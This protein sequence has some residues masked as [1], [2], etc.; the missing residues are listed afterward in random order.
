[1]TR[2]WIFHWLDGICAFDISKLPVEFQFRAIGFPVLIT[3]IASLQISALVTGRNDTCISQSGIALGACSIARDKT[4]SDF[5]GRDRKD[6]RN[7]AGSTPLSRSSRQHLVRHNE[8]VSADSVYFMPSS[9]AKASTRRHGRLRRIPQSSEP[10]SRG[11]Y[12]SARLVGRAH[13]E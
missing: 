13:L 10:T 11:G 9:L 5:E 8:L 2:G 1:M 4:V 7:L 3:S 6:H 12:L